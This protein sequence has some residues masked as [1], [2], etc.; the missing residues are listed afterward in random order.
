MTPVNW[1]ELQAN[2]QESNFEALPVGPYDVEIDKAETKTS[3]TGKTMYAVQFKVLNGPHAGR[4]VFNQFVISPES[5]GAL[6]FFFS[7]MKALGLDAAFFNAGPTDDQVCNALLGRKAMITL[8]M[9]QYQGE[10]RNDV[11]KIA[12]LAG[13]A[14]ASVAPPPPP[15]VPNIPTPPAAGAPEAPF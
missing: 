3:S 8:G 14:T 12:P 9:K 15:G 1:D 11:K 4:K 2:A 6:G 7:H 5:P 10:D 13:G